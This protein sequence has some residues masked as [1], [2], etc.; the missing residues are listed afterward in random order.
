[1]RQFAMSADCHKSVPLP[2]TSI[3]PQL[4][5]TASYLIGPLVSSSGAV[6]VV[7]LQPVSFPKCA[8]SNYKVA[9]THHT[10]FHFSWSSV[11]WKEK[12]GVN[13]AHYIHMYIN[14]IVIKVHI[15][16]KLSLHIEATGNKTNCNHQCISRHIF[17]LSSNVI[18]FGRWVISI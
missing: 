4:W 11:W 13:T 2:P 10:Y 12:G 6:I 17:E 1:M 9:Q 18:C 7:V 8:S 3:V 16:R 15:P 5:S 14:N